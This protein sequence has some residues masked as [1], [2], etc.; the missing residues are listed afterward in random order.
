MA[1][2]GG[3]RTWPTVR[4]NGAELRATSET[5][6]RKLLALQHFVGT[7][8]NSP[9]REQIARIIL[10]GSVAQGDPDPDSDVDVL[11][12]GMEPLAPLG[13]MCADASLETGLTTNES[14]QPL[15]YPLS[16]YT[17]A[18]TLFV[19][20]T[21]REG[22]ELYAMDEKVLW[23]ETSEVYYDLASYYL[24]GAQANLEAQRLR[25]AIDVAYNAAELC[26]KAFLTLRRGRVPKRHGGIITAFSD[27]FVK[28]G[29]FP[30]RV[31]RAL[32]RAFE[33]R[34]KARY[35]GRTSITREMA[36]SVLNLAQELLTGL[37]KYLREWQTAEGH[38]ERQ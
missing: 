29:D 2:T 8:L 38:P 18:G 5:H 17:H 10:F 16:R 7:L 14:V 22:K 6:Y 11:V 33:Y 31:G 19:Y 23:R 25:I 1:A 20:R 28:T 27:E 34:N 24:E 26:A 4:V 3:E 32:N 21:I 12:F 37:E 30:R 36:L 15:V 35:E 13:E 9:A